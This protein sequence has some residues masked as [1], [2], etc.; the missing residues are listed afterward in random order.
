MLRMR[1]FPY[2]RQQ[3]FQVAIALCQPLQHV[4]KIGP[5]VEVVSMRS[6]TAA[7]TIA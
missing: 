5:D 6:V 1:C 2:V 3:F 4:A 7:R